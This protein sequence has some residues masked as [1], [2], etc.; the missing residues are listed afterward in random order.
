VTFTGFPEEALDFYEGLEADNTRPYWTDHK[1]VFDSCVKAPMTALLEELAP[2]FGDPKLFRP[3]RDVRF[4]KDKTPYKTAAGA[5][6]DGRFY[7]QLSAAG[8]YVAAGAYALSTEQ[9][10][11]LRSAIAEPPGAVLAPVLDALERQPGLT[12]IPVRR[13]AAASRSSKVAMI[14]PICCAA[15][16]TAQSGRRRP[17]LTLRR[18]RASGA[19]SCHRTCCSSKARSA[20]VTHPSSSVRVGPTKTSAS[21]TGLIARSSSTQAAKRASARSW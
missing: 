1:A 17:V 15:R 18:A 8:L 7:V 3:Y 4:S 13:A 16:S 2:E 14:P 21:V 11:R 6:V 12:W 20:T 19:S 10:R 5:I 9:A